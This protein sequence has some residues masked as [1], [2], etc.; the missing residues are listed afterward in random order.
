MPQP[1][2]FAGYPAPFLLDAPP[3]A[4]GKRKQ[5]LLWGDHVTLLGEESGDWVKIR[6]R[7]SIG[8]IQRS[9]LQQERLLEINWVD[10]GQGDGIFI[11][12]PGDERILI[13]AGQGDNMHRFLRWRFNLRNH[14]DW[15]I[16]IESAVISHPDGDHYGGFADL[17]ASPNFRFGSVY[18]NGIVERSKKGIG[19]IEDGFLT[20]VIDDEHDLRARLADAAFVGKSEY[21]K[22]LKTAAESG[23]VG[24]FETIDASDAFLTGYE[25]DKELTI[26]V[27]APV[28]EGNRL[29]YFGSKGETKNGHSIVLRMRYRDVRILLGGDLNSRAENYLLKHYTGIDPKTAN[30]QERQTIREQAHAVFGA[31]IAKS[32]HHGSSDFTDL[33]IQ[34][35]DA[36]A[37]VI[38]SGDNEPHAH[39]RPDAL[40][41]IGKHGR[42]DRP[43][44][45]ST[46]LARST[47]QDSARL[48]SMQ[49]EIVVKSLL[50]A[51]AE[52]TTTRE[53]LIG[54]IE[55]LQDRT[56]AVFGMINLRT[57]GDRVL[58]AYKL[59][60]PGSGGREFDVHLLEKGDDGVLQY[61]GGPSGRD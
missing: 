30:E 60:Q 20:D 27:L 13:D 49:S 2:F 52:S 21:P 25:S 6:G 14:P 50:A 3:P 18:H 16:G 36:V 7:N 33:F 45:F 48:T 43:L 10:V 34:V 29:K 39:P 55:R 61:V 38:S 53:Q 26:E 54:D 41:A 5:Q 24:R 8:W 23:R 58:L 32:C 28:R 44:I 17:F 15:T 40:G 46:E 22:V 37:T 57:D 31:D 42:G 47:K 35:V 1:Q 56:V 11:V 4:R 51:S 9:Q 12:T 19:P 59:E